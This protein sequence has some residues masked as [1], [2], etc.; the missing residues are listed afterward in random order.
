MEQFCYL[1]QE[2]EFINSKEPV[3]KIGRTIQQKM[4][5]IQSYPKGSYLI[6]FMKVY[7]CNVAEK[8]IIQTFNNMF[9]QRI[10]IG[11]EYYE[12]NI[13]LIKTAFITVLEVLKVQYKEPIILENIKEKL[14]E[15][16]V[17]LKQEKKE[18][19]TKT[20][21]LNT[22][23]NK[24]ENILNKQQ[25]IIIKCEN[26]DDDL[27]NIINKYCIMNTNKYV[28]HKNL[29]NLYIV[30]NK[31]V[32][33]KAFTKMMKE[34]GYKHKKKND[35]VVFKGLGLKEISQYESNLTE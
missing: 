13:E 31:Q 27:S 34:R 5:R 12:G 4:K 8:L 20:I 16:L 3:Y 24:L 29:Y 7:N 23:I 32:S 35:G 21:E 18:L 11:T 33:R 30:H 6:L 10:D 22:S 26:N 25:K 1:L 9:I 14:Q 28:Y 19:A 15:E 2:R 17:C